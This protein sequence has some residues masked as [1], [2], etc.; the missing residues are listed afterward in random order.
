[1]KV[2]VENRIISFLGRN[3]RYDESLRLFVW[4]LLRSAL[5]YADW[6]V[7]VGLLTGEGETSENLLTWTLYTHGMRNEIAASEQ[8]S[9]ACS[10]DL[11][12]GRGRRGEKETHHQSCLAKSVTHRKRRCENEQTDLLDG[13]TQVEDELRRA[14]S[15]QATRKPRA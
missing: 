12:S 7:L 4:D 14:R 3:R 5:A 9:E 13:R 10:F 6:D 1:V 11:T 8:R 15:V 2:A